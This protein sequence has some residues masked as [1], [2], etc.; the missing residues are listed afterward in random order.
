MID[1]NNNKVKVLPDFGTNGK[2]KIISDHNLKN[3]IDNFENSYQLLFRKWGF[4]STDLRDD[5]LGWETTPDI[6]RGWNMYPLKANAMVLGGI[7]FLAII[8]WA[9]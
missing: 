6:W 3:C 5:V 9:K 8:T 2:Q 1:V 4:E 7:V